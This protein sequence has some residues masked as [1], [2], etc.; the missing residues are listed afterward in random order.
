METPDTVETMKIPSPCLFLTR[1]TLISGRVRDL[2]LT[3]Y[4]GKYLFVLFYREDFESVEDLE[5]L[6]QSLKS[7]KKAGCEVLACS[8]DSS[9]VHLD[10]VKTE[11]HEG[12]FGGNLDIPLVS[13]RF[14]E[15]SKTLGIYDEEEGVCLRSV[16][17]VD[18]K[19]IMRQLTSTSLPI[20]DLIQSSLETLKT[21]KEVKIDNLDNCKV[22]EN[23]FLDKLWRKNLKIPDTPTTSLKRTLSSSSNSRSRNDEK[24]KPEENTSR[25]SRSVSRSQNGAALTSFPLGQSLD[26]DKA[27]G[28]ADT[29]M[30]SL[31]AAL[32]SKFNN[33]IDLPEYCAGEV[34]LHDGR[35]SGIWKVSRGG[36]ASIGSRTDVL[37]LTFPLMVRGML[38]CYSFKGRRVKGELACAYD[39]VVFNV[40]L[41]QR[42]RA[43]VGNSPQLVELS[44]SSV[45]G[46]RM[47]VHG[48]G[49]LNWIAGK[50]VTDLVQQTVLQ[51]VEDELK[52]SLEYQLANL[53]FYFQIVESVSHNLTPVGIIVQ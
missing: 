7:F 14:G 4:K 49:P 25:R 28:F 51:E 11:K 37:I 17:V 29:I 43:E 42:V 27:D 32:K 52:F 19:G 33:E 39:R 41:S 26:Q 35:V 21:L 47:D 30:K 18:D 15:L 44:L 46:V 53:V 38:A 10:W 22:K 13:D 5:E 9:L 6:S 48:F 23:G 24:Q 31:K 34:T 16:L 40:K 20:A 12:G 2:S 36:A 8:T 3:D 50:K 1:P 45:E